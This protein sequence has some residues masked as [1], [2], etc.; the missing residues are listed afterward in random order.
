MH[1]DAVIMTLIMLL[2]FAHRG[3]GQGVSIKEYQLKAVFLFNFTQFVDWPSNSF[4]SDD[5]P[6][7]IGIMGEDPFGS[8]L[9]QTVSGEKAKKHPVM[10]RRFATLDEVKSCHIMFINLDDEKKRVEATESLKARNILTVSDR[11]GFLEEGGMVR[12]M[13]KD[14]KIKLQINPEAS[15]SANLVISSKLLRLAEIFNP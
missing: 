12:F 9:Q 14:N 7:V 1:G 5:A 4:T 6:L 2:I 8:Y 3:T 11:P 15:K 13:T 10:V